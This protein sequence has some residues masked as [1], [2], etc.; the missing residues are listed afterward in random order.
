MVVLYRSAPCRAGSLIKA[1]RGVC[2]MY[3]GVGDW[4]ADRALSLRLT[5]C[6]F[7]SWHDLHI[8]TR[9]SCNKNEARL[10]AQS[11][12]SIK[13][14]W[15]LRGIFTI[16]LKLFEFHNHYDRRRRFSERNS[17]RR[18]DILVYLNNSEK[19]QAKLLF[20]F[21]KLTKNYFTISRSP[22]IFFKVFLH[23]ANVRYR[24][25]CFWTPGI[26]CSYQFNFKYKE[27]LI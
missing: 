24:Y 15:I 4:S 26:D 23:F 27:W 16:P 8:S 13:Q 18:V 1:W 2:V 11:W 12:E 17:C 25:L 14:W 6:P 3:E 21:E 5:S 9:I 10:M 7:C 20:N 22:V 19:S